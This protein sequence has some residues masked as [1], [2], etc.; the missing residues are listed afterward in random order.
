[1]NNSD[2]F[3]RKKNNLALSYKDSLCN[4]EF[5]ISFGKLGERNL[6]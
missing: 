2:L 3:L 1:M 5:K 4:E 6:H